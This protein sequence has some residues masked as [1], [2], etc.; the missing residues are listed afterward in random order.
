[1]GEVKIGDRVDTGAPSGRWYRY[2]VVKEITRRFSY[3]EVL[4][5]HDNGETER[6]GER[7]L[8]VV[9]P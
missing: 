9:E 3:T 2:G 5:E 4:V 1:M 6:Y 8:T 7:Q